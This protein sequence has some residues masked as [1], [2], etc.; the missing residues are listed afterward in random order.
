[1][2]LTFIRNILRL[3]I[4]YYFANNMNMVLKTGMYLKNVITHKAGQKEIPL[5]AYYAERMQ[6][7]LQQ[8]FYITHL[9]EQMTFLESQFT[10]IFDN[11]NNIADLQQD[12]TAYAEFLQEIMESK[13]MRMITL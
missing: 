7:Q 3:E 6:S 13:M 5:L 9:L 4:S 11:N 12:L 1:E 8:G 10:S 2:K